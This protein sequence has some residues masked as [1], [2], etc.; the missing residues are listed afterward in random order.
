MF[1]ARSWPESMRSEARRTIQTVGVLLSKQVNCFRLVVASGALIPTAYCLI[2]LSQ[3]RSLFIN[4]QQTINVRPGRLTMADG[5]DG[6]SSPEHRAL[7]LGA[8]TTRTRT[9][10]TID[11]QIN[12]PLVTNKWAVLCLRCYS[13]V[14]RVPRPLSSCVML[15]TSGRNA[16]RLRPSPLITPADG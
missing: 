3:V 11:R 13:L 8:A 9:H 14:E 10:L 16:G 7:T 1:S 2:R 5:S 6:L 12:W 4:F 15:A